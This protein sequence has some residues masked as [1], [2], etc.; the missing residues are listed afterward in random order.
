MI[1]TELV[2]L[3]F[4]ALTFG[5]HWTLRS[6]SARKLLLLAASYV[7]YGAWDWRFLGLILFSTW[8]DYGIGAA[9]GSSTDARVRRR[10]LVLSCL[11]NLGL[12]AVFKYTNFFIDSAVVLAQRFGFEI[13]ARQLAIVLPVGI[14]FFTFQ[15]MSYTIDVY[16]RELRPVQNVLDFM[17]FVA[18]FPQ[19]VAGPIVRAVDFLPQLDTPRMWSRVNVRWCLTLFLI[20]FVKKACISDNVVEIVDPYFAHPERYDALGAWSAVL[21]YAVQIYCDFSGYS[22]MALATA[23]LFGYELRLNFDWPYL[24]T[25]IQDFWR[26]WHMSLSTW[27]RDYLYI[28][29]G[30]SRGSRLFQHRN[31]M[32]TML[33]GGLWHG[34]GWN[35]VIWGGLHGIALI[36][37]REAQRRGLK[38]PR[39]VGLAATFWWVCL[40]WI[41]FRAQSLDTAWRV[42]R[43]F[44]LF[45]S[46]G[47]TNSGWAPLATFALLAAIHAACARRSLEAWSARVP[48]WSFALGFGVLVPLAFAF[49]N[50]AVQPFIYFQ[51]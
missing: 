43:A 8:V 37:H 27:L 14:S 21:F 2:F 19:L 39:L 7:F 23:G 28:P 6:N 25:S 48:S 13:T 32:L 35:F 10:W 44:V 12:L 40:A 51:F 15:S 5:L 41:F 30:G 26:R 49:M 42:V 17:L 31:L 24:A 20:G 1:F 16:R 9:L 36:A 18:F 4:F 34:A 46:P 29:L 50:G 47:T 22:D 11:V 45:E 38:L 33:L 3:G